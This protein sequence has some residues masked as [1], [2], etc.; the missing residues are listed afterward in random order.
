[1]NGFFYPPGR[2]DQRPCLILN[3]QLRFL[4]NDS[5][6]RG[7]LSSAPISIISEQSS[8]Q[9]NN[10]DVPG[11]LTARF[12][13]L[14]LRVSQGTFQDVIKIRHVHST[15][16]EDDGETKDHRRFL[17]IFAQNLLDLSRSSN[18]DGCIAAIMRPTPAGTND[19]VDNVITTLE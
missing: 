13:G 12:P 4:S 8:E 3:I 18:L 7:W 2:P 14:L 19:D 10:V 9:A 11:R 17:T 1:M 15:E 6:A 16:R 5:L